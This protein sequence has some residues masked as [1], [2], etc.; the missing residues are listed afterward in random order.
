MYRYDRFWRIAKFRSY[1][2]RLLLLSS[3]EAIDYTWMCVRIRVVATSCWWKWNRLYGCFFGEFQD[4][5]SD[6]ASGQQPYHYRKKITQDNTLYWLL[7]FF[8]DHL[9]TKIF[10]VFTWT[11]GMQIPEGIKYLALSRPIDEAWRWR[12]ERNFPVFAL[13]GLNNPGWQRRHQ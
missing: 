9:R 12:A 1:Q 10:G 7:W 5:R 11:L 13:P 3:A 8:T 4:W 2:R 6:T